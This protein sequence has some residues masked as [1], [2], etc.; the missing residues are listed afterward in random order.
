MLDTKKKKIKIHS[1]GSVGIS[2]DQEINMSAGNISIKASKKLQLTGAETINIDS[3]NKIKMEG[4]DVKISGDMNMEIGGVNTTIEGE[5]SLQLKSTG[6]NVISGLPIK[7][8]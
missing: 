2:A 8:N 7:I 5:A 4:V 6:P 1:K 3:D